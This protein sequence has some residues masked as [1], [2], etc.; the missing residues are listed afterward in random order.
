LDLLREAVAAGEAFDRHLA[1]LE[2]RVR[3][4]EGRPQLYGTQ[5]TRVVLQY[6]Y[7][8]LPIEDPERVDDRGAAVGLG[9]LAGY[10]AHF[11]ERDE[12]EQQE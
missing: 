1:Y 10:A 11:N 4:A 7:E 2:D 3:T 5:F 9:P 12:Q 6:R 8:P